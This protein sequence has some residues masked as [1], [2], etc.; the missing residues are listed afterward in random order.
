MSSL[1]ARYIPESIVQFIRLNYLLILGFSILCIPTIADLSQDLWQTPEQ[2]HGP[3]ILAIILWLFYKTNTEGRPAEA[4]SN[5]I[6]GAI[7]FSVG[8]LSYILGR[9]QEIWLFEVGAF[10]PMLSGLILLIAGSAALKKY[11]FAISFIVFL[12]PLPGVVVDALTSGLKS[13]VSHWAEVLLYAANYPVARS[14]VMLVVGQYQLLVADACSGMNSLFSLFALGLLYIHIGGYGFSW[15]GIFLFLCVV[16]IAFIANVIRV[17]ILILVTYHFGDAAGQGFIHGFAGM[18]VF[19]VALI[20]F[21]IT[22][23][24]LGLIFVKKAAK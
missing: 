20:A 6:S 23:F 13:Q 15:R 3:F 2:G 5:N 12:I 4:R 19:A 22:D 21:F 24:L 11:F 10:I 8:A 16:P 7:I 1:L 18:V 17:M 9:S 14:G